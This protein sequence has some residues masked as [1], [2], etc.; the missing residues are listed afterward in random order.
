MN[1]SFTLQSLDPYILNDD[2]MLNYLKY[3][4]PTNYQHQ[5]AANKNTH[6]S[7]SAIERTSMI[8]EREHF[9]IPTQI[10]SLFWCYYIL[11]HGQSQYEILNNKSILTARQ[12]KIQ[13]VQ[14][15]R[16]HKTDLKV[17]KLDT[18]T[19]LESNL[20]NDSTLNLKT[21]MALCLL[22]H[23][24]VILIRKHTYFELHGSTDSDIV[25]FIK[26][27][28]NKYHADRHQYGIY[29]GGNSLYKEIVSSHYKM[30][31]L[32]KPIKAISYYK[33]EDLKHIAQKL[34]IFIQG[35]S[36]NDLY[37]SILHYFL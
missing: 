11:K 22:D 12:I 6:T 13:Y 25:Y 20:A 35:K 27:I 19:N 4:I 34:D 30:E 33:L 15:L 29:V 28:P 8:P 21:F 36:K 16:D 2:N 3:N 18:L 24:H 1:H 37:Q 23:L 32:D 17:H 9:Y 31:T 7:V 14:H 26:E 5:N 10:D